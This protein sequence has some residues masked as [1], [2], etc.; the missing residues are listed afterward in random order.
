MI[1]DYV[2]THTGHEFDE[3]LVKS[4]LKHRK[5]ID[6]CFWPDNVNEI[7]DNLKRETE[8]IAKVIL[9]RMESNSLTSM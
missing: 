6:R 4:L 5:L 3:D 9:K 7:M 1:Q 8:P 2:N